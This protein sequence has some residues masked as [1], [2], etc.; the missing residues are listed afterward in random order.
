MNMALPTRVT[1]DTNLQ[2]YVERLKKVTENSV[3]HL[4]MRELAEEELLDT[5]S[6]PIQREERLHKQYQAY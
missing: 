6:E 1:S 2:Q 3:A 5:I 4:D